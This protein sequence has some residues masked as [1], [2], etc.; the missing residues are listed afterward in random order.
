[1]ILTAWGAMTG[2]L[3]VKTHFS[4]KRQAQPPKETPTKKRKLDMPSAPATIDECKSEDE[5]AKFT[6]E[7]LKL[8]LGSNGLKKSGLKFQLIERILTH[9][10]MKPIE[11]TFFLTC[12]SPSSH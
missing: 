10:G 7:E 1:M 11:N 2:V 3:H 12:P 4:M 8:Y 6:V 5:L 9:L